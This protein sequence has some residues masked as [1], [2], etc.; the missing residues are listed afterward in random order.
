M[1]NSHSDSGKPPSNS[2]LCHGDSSWR[3]S[4]RQNPMISGHAEIHFCTGVLQEHLFFP[5]GSLPTVWALPPP[6]VPIS[7][8]C[9]H[10]KASP[11]MIDL[12]GKTAEA[13][14]MGRTNHRELELAQPA[15][16]DGG[17]FLE[18]LRTAQPHLLLLTVETRPGLDFW[19]TPQCLVL[20][21]PN[22]KTLGLG[23]GFAGGRCKR[24]RSSYP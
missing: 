14:A 9:Q 8:S 22:H 23:Q 7:R 18:E 13:A 12:T 20:H 21:T 17:G 19:Q 10:L 2:D 6:H 4:A 11:R 3:S 16:S 1:F 24:P 15:A 5:L